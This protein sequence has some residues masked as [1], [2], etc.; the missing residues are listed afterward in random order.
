MINIGSERTN[1]TRDYKNFE[2]SKEVKVYKVTMPCSKCDGEMEFTGESFLTCPPYNVHKCNKCGFKEEFL[3][4]KY[5]RT[6]YK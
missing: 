2:V 3:G 6:E 4:V 1:R 5:P